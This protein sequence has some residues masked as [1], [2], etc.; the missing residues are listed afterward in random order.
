MDEKGGTTFEHKIAK[1]AH[2]NQ[3]LNFFKKKIFQKIKKIAPH[4]EQF[5]TFQYF[6]EP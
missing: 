1:V 3:K 5:I 4:E 6:F 2:K